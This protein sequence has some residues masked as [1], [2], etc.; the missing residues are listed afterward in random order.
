MSG[1]AFLIIDQAFLLQLK[2]AKQINNLHNR[3][4][5]CFTILNKTNFMEHCVIPR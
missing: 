1:I 5:V 4:V 2:L 3:S